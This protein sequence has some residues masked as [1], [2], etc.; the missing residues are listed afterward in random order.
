M[1][2]IIILLSMHLSFL[3][4]CGR[5]PTEVIFQSLGSLFGTF[6][7]ESE[8]ARLFWEMMTSSMLLD[9]LDTLACNH[10]SAVYYFNNSINSSPA[11]MGYPCSDY[12]NFE[13]GQCTSCGVDKSQCQPIGYHASPGRTLAKLYLKTLHGTKAPFFGNREKWMWRW[14][15]DCSSLGTHLQVT[16]TSDDENDPH[17][18]GTTTL[19]FNGHPDVVLFK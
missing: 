7:M 18:Q 2:V 15:I 11:A 12:K 6:N 9:A 17:T 5:H 16:V 1:L 14:T 3:I 13:D 10:M 4:A 8:W 19:R